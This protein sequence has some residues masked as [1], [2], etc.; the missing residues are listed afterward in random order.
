MEHAEDS[1]VFLF[2]VLEAEV[3]V[4][5]RGEWTEE[6]PA[7]VSG[8]CSVACTA[9]IADN[10]STTCTNSN[11]HDKTLE[12]KGPTLLRSWPDTPYHQG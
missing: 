6:G 3:A 1:D 7:S 12:E 2:H 11:S 8:T 9:A 4:R 5:S 10:L